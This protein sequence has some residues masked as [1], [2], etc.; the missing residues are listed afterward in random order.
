[1]IYEFPV[2]WIGVSAHTLS[3]CQVVEMNDGRK[4]GPEKTEFFVEKLVVV[5]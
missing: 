1:L 2:A 4:I 5:A 3:A